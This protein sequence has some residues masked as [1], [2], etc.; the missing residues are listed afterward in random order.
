[1]R[2]RI[3][4]ML[5]P[6]RSA[7]GSVLFV[8]RRGYWE[9]PLHAS[10]CFRSHNGQG[11]CRDS[12]FP[13][14]IRRKRTH[15]I[16][17]RQCLFENV[18]ATNG[19]YCSWTVHNLLGLLASKRHHSLQMVSCRKSILQSL[20]TRRSSGWA[21]VTRGRWGRSRLHPLDESTG[22]FQCM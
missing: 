15:R 13:E 17:P 5:R 14:V 18:R 20:R 8:H 16:C 2:V 10:G 1:M 11:K 21:G 19:R 12:C 6:S 4:G 3:R 9:E 22:I 7:S